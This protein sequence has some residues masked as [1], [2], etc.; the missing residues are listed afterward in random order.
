VTIGNGQVTAL[1]L[2]S[3]ALW[4]VVE[5]SQARGLLLG[6]A[7]SKYS[8]PPVLALFLLLRRRWRLLF[9]SALPPIVGFL[10]FYA[11]LR[12]P[13]WT[14]AA[15]PFRCSTRNVSPGLANAMAVSGIF[16]RRPPWFQ[17]VPDAFYLSARA[18]WGDF[19]PYICGVALALA[20][21]MYFFWRG[22]EVDGRIH[23]AC[24]TAASLLCFKHQIYDFLLLIFCLAIALKAERSVARNWLLLLIAYFWYAE[25][26]VHI[27][28]WEFWPSVVIASF[29]LLIGLI[30][31]AWKLR[32]T[33]HWKM[34]WKL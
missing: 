6:V 27:R 32:E 19:V 31:A 5:S 7:W 30:G 10:F 13:F 3:L 24:L 29:V 20:V 14:L 28:R 22:K 34:N 4:A 18:G 1:V 33:L 9:W 12:T 26:L 25:R 2:A 23:L 21:A 8:V 15:E 16:L 11:W 17:T